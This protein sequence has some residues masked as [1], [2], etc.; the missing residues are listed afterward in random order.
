MFQ[1]LFQKGRI[2]TS[3]QYMHLIISLEDN[4]IRFPSASLLDTCVNAV[5]NIIAGGTSSQMDNNLHR[6]L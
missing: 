1:S 4:A 3:S 6:F 5:N 2:A